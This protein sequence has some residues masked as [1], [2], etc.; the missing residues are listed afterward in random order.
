MRLEQSYF[1]EEDY[2]DV[3]LIRPE[4]TQ[5]EVKEAFEHLSKGL[6]LTEP[7]LA[8][9]VM[10][11]EKMLVLTQ[12]YE[13]LSDPIQRS[14]YDLR[15]LGRKNLPVSDQVDGLFREAV[16]A[17]KQHQLEMALR[18]FKEI[19]LLYPHRPLYRVH[20]AISYAEKNWMTF[21]EAELETALR[22]DP[23]FTFAKETVA[24]LLFQLPDKTVKSHNNQLNREVALL[25]AGFVGLGF[26]LLSGVPQKFLGGVVGKVQQATEE[27]MDPMKK[28]ARKAG[29]NGANNDVTSQLPQ[30]MVQELEAKN[31]QKSSQV[32]I[33]EL[34]PDF[35]PE[36]QTY[37]YRKQKAKAKTFYPEQGIVVVTYEDGSILTYRPAEL[38]GWQNDPETKQAVMVTR[39]NEL[40]PAPASLPLKLPDGSEAN[41]KAPDFPSQLFP[42][43]ETDKSAT[44]GKPIAPNSVTTPLPVQSTGQE[45]PT[46]SSS[47]SQGGNPYTPYAGAGR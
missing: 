26:L 40:I 21:A 27:I 28:A 10:A 3:L 17:Y 37:D 42:E 2:Y 36:G 16:K 12:A 35:K 32:N 31:A 19:S 8:L 34:G 20:L 46:G 43:Y 25:A 29:K 13:V 6:N 33:P 9:R 1:V 30:D 44:V 38:Q 41:L 23:D 39:Q 18:F 45:N 22:L 14:H 7:N 4:A 15:H 47:A 24:H 11:A 5:L